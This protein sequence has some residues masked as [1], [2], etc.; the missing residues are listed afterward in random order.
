LRAPRPLA[1]SPS[2]VAFADPRRP[3][4]ILPDTPLTALHEPASVADY[5]HHAPLVSGIDGAEHVSPVAVT[6]RPRLTCKRVG[7]RS[8]MKLVTRPLETPVIPKTTVFGAPPL[9]SLATR[10]IFGKFTLS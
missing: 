3:I 7:V 9:T 10:L 8:A 6:S 5:N 4:G 2:T 1:I